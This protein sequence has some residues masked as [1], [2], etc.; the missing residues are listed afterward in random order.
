MPYIISFDADVLNGV[1]RSAI[2][3]SPG[4]NIIS[5]ENGTL[6]TKLLQQ[7]K[8]HPQR[9]EVNQGNPASLRIRAISPR[10]N[11]ERKAFNE[12]VQRFRSQNRTI[13]TVQ[14]EWTNARTNDQ[15]FEAYP[16]LA[17]VFYAVYL[18]RCKDGG[19]QKEKMEAVTAE[20]GAVIR[21]TLPDY[22]LVSE[23]MPTT[24]APVLKV[25]KKAAVVVPI[26]GLSLGEQE[27][28]SLVA[29]VHAARESYDVYLIDEPEAHLNWHLEER[30]FGFLDSFCQTHSKQVIVATHS[31]VV[32]SPRFMA[33]AQFLAWS[34]DGHVVVAPSPTSDQLARIAGEAVQVIQLQEFR[35]RTLFVEDAGHVE[36]LNAI[37]EALGTAVDVIPCGNASN[38]RSLFRYSKTQAEWENAYFICDGDN[39]GNPYPGESRFI[40]LHSYCL[41]NYLLVP[42][43]AARGIDSSVEDA[44]AQLVLA[45]RKAAGRLAKGNRLVEGL[46]ARVSER[47]LADE[48]LFSADGSAILASLLALTGAQRSSYI[49]AYVSA[50]AEKKLLDKIF[51]PELVAAIASAGHG[52]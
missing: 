14:T 48:E 9:A 8:E 19:L 45:V 13:E 27:V 40:H 15:T 17:E 21:Q 47:D 51:P 12:V 31:R 23:W 36:V 2:S 49:T 18:D 5:G 30:L 46:L 50:C 24:G 42:E 44:E 34:S 28:L 22:E 10:R 33:K 25:R 20:F 32:F 39:Q 35:R 29:N 16:S 52:A 26:E 37:A 41:E 43:F 1:L 6:K 4:L 3:F 7:V 11:A 38:V